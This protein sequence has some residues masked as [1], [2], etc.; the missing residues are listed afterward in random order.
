MT[1]TTLPTK[2]EAREDIPL[3][4][5]FFAYVPAAIAGFARWSK[6]GND[7]HNKGEPLHHARWKS[8]NHRD[9][10]LRHLMDINDQLAAYERGATV[11]SPEQVQQLMD[12]C[13]A[14]FWRAGLLSQELHER[15]EGA[16]LAPAAKLP[17]PS[18]LLK[19]L[20]EEDRRTLET[21]PITLGPLIPIRND[22]GFRVGSRIDAYFDQAGHAQAAGDTQ[23][24]KDAMEPVIEQRRVEAMQRRVMDTDIAAL[25]VGDSYGGVEYP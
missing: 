12:D 1:R 17:P 4:D 14:L 11:F 6:I 24:H 2:S 19:P 9:K 16:P 7:K 13:D 3:N 10:I 15:F 5:G 20:S 21:C 25:E 23:R 22:A 18:L 8:M